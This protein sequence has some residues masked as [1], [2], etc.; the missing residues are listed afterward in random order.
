MALR[1]LLMPNYV[2]AFNQGAEVGRENRT[3]KTLSEF[4]QPAIGG[5]QGALAKIYG[6][7]PEAGMKAQQFGQQQ[8]DASRERALAELKQSATLWSAAPPEMRPHIYEKIRTLAEQT[9]LVPLGKAPMTLDTPEA[10][11][12][13]EKFIAAIAGPSQ[14][15]RVQSRFVDENGNVKALLASGRVIDT[16]NRAAPNIKILEQEGQVP[17]GYVTS[18]GRAGSAVPL[19]GG[20]APQQMPP[21]GTRQISDFKA[22]GENLGDGSTLDFSQLPQDEQA[23]FLRSLQTGGQVTLPP[24]GPV[25]TPTAGERAYDAEVGTQ[26]ARTELLPQQEAI[27][28]SADAERARQEAA[29]KNDAEIASKDLLRQRSAN[30][31]L[32]LIDQAERLIPDSTGSMAG[33]LTDKGMGIFGESTKGAE[34]IAALKTVAGQLVAKMPRMEGPQSNADVQMYKDMAG[35]L[36]NP[37]TPR[38]Q[39]LAALQMIR[40]LNEKYGDA[41]LPKRGTRGSMDRRQPTVIRYDAQGNRIK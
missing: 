13:F 12:N 3:R 34:N 36:A 9:N 21:A 6:A 25:R 32:A 20:A 8:Q 26:R 22:T 7:N 31:A 29:I 17:T 4:L 2:G 28:T 5:D 16:G 41:G 11:Q 38:G 1:E 23:A 14:G 35:D 10:Q 19:G 30:E 15:D 18:G 24:A 39:R 37:E 27:K 40:A 33:S